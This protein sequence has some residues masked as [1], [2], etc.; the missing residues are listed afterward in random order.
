MSVAREFETDSPA[1]EYLNGFF[2]AGN[3]SRDG[4]TLKIDVY[5][6]SFDSKLVARSD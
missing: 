6:V 4:M 2:L 5:G 3:L 1:F